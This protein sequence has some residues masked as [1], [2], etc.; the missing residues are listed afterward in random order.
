M[1]NYF[2]C[3]SL[4][5]PLLKSL[6]LLGVTTPYH[7]NPL[8]QLRI[9]INI[10]LTI[11]AVLRQCPALVFLRDARLASGGGGAGGP[12]AGFEAAAG[13]ACVGELAHGGVG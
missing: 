6:L 5:Q 9:S 13:V 1:I 4:P 12:D 8:Q 11:G 10:R 3:N 7:L 2:H